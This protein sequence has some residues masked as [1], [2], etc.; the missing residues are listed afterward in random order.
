MG[1]RDGWKQLNV[2]VSPEL[3]DW[4]HAARG[5]ISKQVFVADIL[6]AAMKAQARLPATDQEAGR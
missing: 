3:W 2:L 1:T 4:I 5:K 6:E